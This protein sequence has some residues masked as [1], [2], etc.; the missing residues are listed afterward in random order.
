M[1][2]G[3]DAGECGLG[4]R[5]GSRRP[6]TAPPRFSCCPHRSIGTSGSARA[7]G[8]TLAEF[9]RSHAECQGFH[10]DPDPCHP[11]VVECFADTVMRALAGRQIPPQR[12]GLLFV[13]SGHGDAGSRAQSYRLMRLLWEQ[14]SLG[15]ADVAFLRHAQVFLGTALER[16][17]ARAA[18]LDTGPAEP[19]AD[20]TRGL[21]PAPY[22]T[23]SSVRTP[24]RAEWTLASPPGDHP[25]LS[26]WLTQR[27]TRLWREKRSRDE[28]RRPVSQIGG[29]RSA[30][31]GSGRVTD[32]SRSTTARPERAS[33]PARAT[34]THWRPCS[35]KCCRRPTRIL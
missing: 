5:V 10:D 31:R 27:M 9:R 3:E 21:R 18:A 34:A 23:I 17:A 33:S 13:A 19:M 29:L 25:S 15:R 12:A 6:R 1:H 4:A 14:L 35:R 7:F 11:L 30:R 28:A 24:I 26:A 16:C 2:P 32:G 20:R 22:W 8:R